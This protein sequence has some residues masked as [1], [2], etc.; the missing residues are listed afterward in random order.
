MRSKTN[1][2]MNTMMTRL[3]FSLFLTATLAYADTDTDQDMDGVPDMRDKCQDTPF[4]TEVDSSGC[5]TKELIFPQ[6]RNDGNLDIV[7]G[8]GYSY[9]DDD[10]MRS[11]Q[12]TVRLQASYVL[13]DWICTLRTGYI[14]DSANVGMTDTVFK[15]K[16]R[17]KPVT[18]FKFSIGAGVR[19]PTYDFQGNNTDFTLYSSAIYYPLSGVSLFGGANY[20]FIRDDE[21]DNPLQNITA[22]YIGTGYFFNEDLYINA[23]YSYSDTKFRDYHKIR[24]LSTTLF[25]QFSEK[26]FVTFSYGQEIEDTDGNPRST[27]NVRLGY[28]VW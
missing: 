8:Y 17:F 28:S 14:T 18:N 11:E 24:T 4:L 21:I 6:E 12:H 3:L 20:T 7:V 19:L 5:P 22:L 26:W 23:S 27:F 16:K 10:F 13:D 15:V 1:W 9:D 2:R 25:Y